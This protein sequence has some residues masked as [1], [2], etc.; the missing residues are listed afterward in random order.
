MDLSRFDLNLL[1]TLDVLDRE[2]SV[3]IAAVRLNVT[4][5]AVSHAL[6]RLRRSL[7]DPL[8]ARSGQEL[9]P[10]QRCSDILMHVRPFLSSVSLALDV[11]RSR[12]PAFHPASDRR[13]LTVVL[14]GAVEVSL[15]PSLVRHIAQKAP[16][17]EIAVRGF[18]RRSYA[19]DLLSGETD[20]VLSVGGHTPR[21]PDLWIETF[22]Q[23]ELVAVQGAYGPLS[24][25]QTISL[26][27]AVALP[28]VYCVPWPREQNYLDIRLARAGRRRPIALSL[29]S[30]ATAGEVLTGTQLIAILPDRTALRL[31][32]QYSDLRLVRM[33]PP[34]RTPLVIETSQRFRESAA[35]AWFLSELHAMRDAVP[36]L[37]PQ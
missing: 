19:T 10:T 30:Y 21:S 12:N 11:D 6:A 36:C 29:P 15:L 31:L 13:T 14:P 26:E 24:R 7:G 16:G 23:D 28:Q 27:E 17:W 4:A 8:F 18:E 34:V 20:I 1:K 37:P 22:W 32:Q 3:Q 25:D 9:V 2:R 5:S 33:D 35:G